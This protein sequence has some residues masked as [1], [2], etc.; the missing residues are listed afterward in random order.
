MALWLRVHKKNVA[1]LKK[2]KKSPTLKKIAHTTK[3]LRKLS[4]TVRFE[5]NIVW[6]L[7]DGTCRLHPKGHLKKDHLRR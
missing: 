3:M 7:P 5:L 4:K 2:K 1:S 6:Q